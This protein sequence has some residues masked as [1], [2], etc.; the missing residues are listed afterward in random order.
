MGAPRSRGL[1]GCKALA[2]RD[3]FSASRALHKSRFESDVSR[4]V[5]RNRQTADDD[6]LHLSVG[7]RHER[8]LEVDQARFP[9]EPECCLA[10]ALRGARPRIA[11]S[12]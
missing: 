5:N 9:S 1:K 4:A 12:P 3:G 7:E 11:S 8:F 10:T 2:R 6:E